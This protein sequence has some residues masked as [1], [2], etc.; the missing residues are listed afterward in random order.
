MYAEFNDTKKAIQHELEVIG[1]T[2]APGLAQAL[3]DMNPEQLQPTFLGMVKSPTV[4]GMIIKDEKGLVVGS[5]GEFPAENNNV[6][7]DRDEQQIFGGFLSR[8]FSYSFPIVFIQDNKETNVGEA[9][10]YSNMEVVFNEVKLGFMFIIANAII[11]TIV[12]WFLVLWV[13]RS[14]LSKPLA[15]LTAATEELTLDQVESLQI[16]LKIRHRNELKMLEESFNKM[17][18]NLK[19]S[20]KE[21]AEKNQQFEAVV[22]GTPSV[23]FIKN[24]D[25]RYLFVNPQFEALFHVKQADLVGKTDHDI[26]PKDMAD[27]FKENDITVIRTKKPLEIE[28]LAPHDDGVHTYISTKYPLFNGG[29]SSHRGLRDCHGHYRAEKDRGVVK[30]LQ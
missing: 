20:R 2:F 8:F 9:V 13:S 30:E 3:W 28:E 19:H 17:I 29:R 18:Q 27:T 10:I 23:I 25:G 21:L 16:D 1:Q 7:K 5:A 11:K 4:T 22:V 14:I 24:A 15:Q 12:L 6:I 26:F